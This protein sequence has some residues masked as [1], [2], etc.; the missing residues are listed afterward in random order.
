MD[1]L[2]RIKLHLRQ[3]A[4]HQKERDGVVLLTEAKDEIEML[5]SA[6]N[7]TLEENGH[8]ADGDNCTLIRLKQ[9]MPVVEQRMCKC[10]MPW[11]PDMDQFG[12]WSCGAEEPVPNEP[13]SPDGVAVRVQRVVSRLP[14]TKC[15]TLKRKLKCITEMAARQRMATSSCR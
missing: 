7:T 5:R 9:V 14:S 4:P 10:E 12:C 11:E 3:L 8:L 13:S 1:L 2:E 15:G 6:I